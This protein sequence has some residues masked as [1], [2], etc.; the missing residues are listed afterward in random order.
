[1]DFYERFCDFELKHSLYERKLFNINYWEYI[2]PGINRQVSSKIEGYTPAIILPTL[3]IK[4]LI[5]S[6]NNLSSYFLTNKKKNVDVLL[7][8]HPRRVLIDGKYENLYTDS[9]EK[10]LKNYKCLTLEE[11]TWSASIV[12]E[13]SHSFPIKTDNI[14]FTDFYEYK[15]LLKKI[16]FKIF[17]KKEYYCMLEEYQYLK[18]TIESHFKI[19]DI[20]FGIFYWECLLRDYLMYNE[21]KKLIKKINPKSILL[22]YFP[23]FFKTMLINI[24]N[25]LKIPTIEIQHG[26]ITDIDPIV[27][28]CKKPELLRSRTDYMFAFSEKLLKMYDS[29][30]PQENVKYVGYPFLENKIKEQ[31]HFPDFFDKNKKYILI[32]SQ[33]TI[34][35]KMSEFASDLAEK[36]KDKKD[37]V[38]L[39]K[40]HPNEIDITFQCLKKK[41]IIE[42]NTLDL[43]IYTLQ[44]MSMLQIGSYSTALYEG[45]KF[46]TATC[47]LKSI[48]GSEHSDQILNYL[49]QGYY[50]INNSDDIL[51]LINKGIKKP[52]VSE[53]NKL[54]NDNSNN[55]IYKELSK[56]IGVENEK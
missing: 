46:G 6:F 43:D 40:Y 26:T 22:H 51:S 9:Y 18:N 36:I 12:S 4:K 42:I 8:S 7:V 47:V 27:N 41:N 15:F 19:K 21:T 13:Y 44:K 3:N 32:I 16:K 20:N 52:K 25:E 39:F 49:T 54:W 55:K 10:L 30:V 37:Y 34:G 31:T 11:P 50:P 14:Y 45:L 1:M 53:V 23:S 48:F 29:T 35:N 56:I 5:P 28:K 17:N 2:R 33:S 38:I 24:G